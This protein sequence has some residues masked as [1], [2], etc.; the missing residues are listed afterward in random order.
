MHQLTKRSVCVIDVDSCYSN[1]SWVPELGLL[2]E[3]KEILLCDSSWLNDRHINAAQRLLKAA[4][5]NL[6]GFQNPL[7]GQTLLYDIEPGEFVQILHD[8]GGHW[9]TV[10]TVGTTHPYIN[11]F[12]SLYPF[13]S[14]SVKLQIA[15]ML[16]TQQKEIITTFKDVQMQG[17]S[18]DCGVFAIAFATAITF[19]QDPGCNMFEQR[20]LRSHLI[21]CFEKMEI[22]MFPI[23]KKRRVGGRTKSTDSIAVYCICRLP[24]IPPRVGSSVLVVR[25]G[26]IIKYVLM[27][28]RNFLLPNSHGSVISV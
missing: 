12:D 22:L 6:P 18:S 20:L 9:L 1:K 25:S 16:C 5:P 8:G 23:L 7:F 14:P 4:N 3:D 24:S 26:S 13:T 17:G 2:W 10:S 11:V 15:S 21:G 28:P 27:C 19:G